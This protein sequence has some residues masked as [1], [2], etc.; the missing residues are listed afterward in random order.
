MSYYDSD[1]EPVDLLIGI[2]ILVL[3]VAAVVIFILR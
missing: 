3:V 1:P 2:L